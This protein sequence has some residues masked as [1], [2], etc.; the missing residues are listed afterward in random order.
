MADRDTGQVR[1]VASVAH[2]VLN[3]APCPVLMVRPTKQTVGRRAR[4]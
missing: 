1:A 4:Q 2:R 3:H